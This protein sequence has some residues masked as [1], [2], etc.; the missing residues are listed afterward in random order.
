[1]LKYSVKYPS[2]NVKFSPKYFILVD[3]IANGTVFLIYDLIFHRA[4]HVWKYKHDDPIQ[5]RA[6]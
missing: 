3:A 1:M 5:N 6:D 4:V 2:A